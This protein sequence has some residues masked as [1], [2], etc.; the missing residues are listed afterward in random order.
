MPILKSLIS[1]PC[2]QYQPL[3]SGFVETASAAPLPTL[4]ISP[5]LHLAERSRPCRVHWKEETDDMDRDEHNRIDTSSIEDDEQED[6]EHDDDALLSPHEQSKQL[7]GHYHVRPSVRAD[8][9]MLSKT[10][11]CSISHT[12]QDTPSKINSN[13]KEH[14]KP[15]VWFATDDQPSGSTTKTNSSPGRT[16]VSRQELQ[17]LLHKQQDSIRRACQL[18][19]HL[20]NQSAAVRAKRMRMVQRLQRLQRLLNNGDDSINSKDNSKFALPPVYRGLGHHRHLL[21]TKTV[22]QTNATSIVAVIDMTCSSSD[23]SSSGTVP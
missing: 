2:P 18:E 7:L 1:S 5:S 17:Q 6:E 10:P 22:S 9:I 13:H 3:L 23:E 14:S 4:V 8:K 12:D 21:K 11:L 19:L 16:R 20:L 15:T